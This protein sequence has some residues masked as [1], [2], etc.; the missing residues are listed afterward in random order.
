MDDFAYFAYKVHIK[1]KNSSPIQRYL[2]KL[3]NNFGGAAINAAMVLIVPRTLGPAHYGDFNFLRDSFQEIVGILDLNIGAAHFNYSS[4][5]KETITATTLYFYF[6]LALGI[7]LLSG[8]ALVN[9]AGFSV[10]FWPGQKIGYIYAGATLA[11]LMHLSVGLT[12][13]SDSKEATVGLEIRRIIV[14]IIGFMLLLALFFNRVL[15]LSTFFS[16]QILIFFLFVI[17]FAIY[18]R[19]KNVFRFEFA[20]VNLRDS[21]EVLKYFVSYSHPLLTLSLFSFL[22]VYFDRWFLQII[23]GSVSQGYYS[24]ALRLSAVCILFTGAMVP[25]FRQMVA[26]AHGENNKAYIQALFQKSRIFYFVSA[27]FSIFFLFHSGEIIYLIGGAQYFEAKVPLM[28]MLCYPIHQTYGQFC[29]SML[30]SLERTDLSRNI[31]LFS[32]ALGFTFSYF[33]IAPN[34]FF[35]PGMGLGAIGLS[36]KMITT[37]VIIVNVTLFYVCKIIRERFVRYLSFQFIVLIPL[38]II[39]Y[40]T[41]DLYGSFIDESSGV[42]GAVSQ[43]LISGFSYLIL[44]TALCWIFPGLLGLKRHELKAYIGKV[45]SLAGF[46]R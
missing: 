9:Q 33:L 6:C 4:K 16:L 15:T 28:I 14:T 19:N 7:I 39:G 24:L 43:L 34:S 13:L 20:K 23:S 41:N 30:M 45:L 8:I 17:V 5:Y 1:L 29:G 32:L 3:I 37:Q 35:I 25:I 22:F 38:L 21:K 46:M 2:S 40:V 12:G 10:Y 11:Y 18:L 36:L 42:I 44:V 31:G 26:K 27:F